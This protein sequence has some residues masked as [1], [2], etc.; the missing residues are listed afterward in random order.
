MFVRNNERIDTDILRD[1]VLVEI[2][3]PKRW[4]AARL[5]A[6]AGFGKPGI[7]LQETPQRVDTEAKLAPA[8]LRFI[9]KISA[10]IWSFVHLPRIYTTVEF[11]QSAPRTTN[12][13]P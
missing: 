9:H 4:P 1:R 3:R 12:W 6:T 10:W 13:K 8:Y 2:N 11:D 7:A 5:D